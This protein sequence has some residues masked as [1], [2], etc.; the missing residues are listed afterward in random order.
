MLRTGAVVGT[1]CDL[2]LA[3]LPLK[4]TDK[5]L[6]LSRKTDQIDA[7]AALDGIYVLRTSLPQQTLAD[8]DVVLRYKGLEDVE[9]A[10]I[11]FYDH[12]KNFAAAKRADVRMDLRPPY[13]D[14]HPAPQ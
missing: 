10:S 13:S 8:H 7:E 6:T 9:R 11:L 14:I 12:D 2:V 1:N 4:C 3:M 5:A